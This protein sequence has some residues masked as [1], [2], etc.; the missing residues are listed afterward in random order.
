[1]QPISAPIPVPGTQQAPTTPSSN[2]TNSSNSSDIQ[3]GVVAGITTT[4]SSSSTNNNGS[5]GRTS[6]SSARVATHHSQGNANNA[7]L[8]RFPSIGN[9]KKL[10]LENQTLRAKIAELERYL[11]GLKE[12][13]ILANRQIHA[14][15]LEIKLA[16][17]RKGEE[18]HDLAQQLQRA[19]FDLVARAA[20]VETLQNQLQ[21]QA[22]EQ[23]SKI[24]HI[25]M[26][27]TE[28]QDYKRMSVT[29][30]TGAPSSTANVALPVASVSSIIRAALIAVE[31]SESTERDVEPLELDE[32]REGDEEVRSP[33]EGVA[34]TEIQTSAALEE[35][36]GE[37]ARKDEQIQ[38]LV[39]KL[40]QLTASLSNVEQEKTLTAENTFTEHGDSKAVASSASGSVSGSDSTQSFNSA[41][42]HQTSL[43]NIG[44]IQ[45]TSLGAINSVGYDV[46]VEHPKLLARYQALRVQHAQASEYV[47]T[48]ESEN[49][50][51][52]IQLLDVSSIDL[53]SGP[54]PMMVPGEALSAQVEAH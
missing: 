7:S 52:K 45:N 31:G 2:G 27:E 41:P 18:L 39:A 46:S 36:R 49:R 5:H 20:E 44:K 50:D 47:D 38:E 10:T 12:E 13:L 19:E 21:H 26:L 24:K 29:S 28:I 17:E 4:T 51:L 32:D 22:K 35:L 11:T 8:S 54:L 48:L 33:A 42:S 6:S 37:N 25:D 23:M 15:N 9:T 14:R 3:D 40:D 1:M 34:A 30:G 53:M 16:Q 43:S